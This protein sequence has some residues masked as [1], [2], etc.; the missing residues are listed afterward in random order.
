MSQLPASTTVTFR[1]RLWFDSYRFQFDGSASNN[2]QIRIQRQLDDTYW[3]GSDWV[4]SETWNS[5]TVDSTNK[6]HTYD[7]DT[8][9][10]TG[11]EMLIV[12]MRVNSDEDT[13]DDD[14]FVIE[15]ESSAG[16]DFG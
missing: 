11:G 3:D 9:P 14:E 4:S 8:S 12:T 7:F 2:G 13:Q 1:Q 6:E 15:G 5:T 16:V 10:L